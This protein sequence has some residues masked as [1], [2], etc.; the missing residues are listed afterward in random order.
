MVYEGM[1]NIL[2]QI[3]WGG[4]RVGYFDKS[5]MGFKKKLDV[6]EKTKTSKPYQYQ[7]ELQIKTKHPKKLIDIL[8]ITTAKHLLIAILTNECFNF[9]EYPNI[10]KHI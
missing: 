10:S 2:T 6:G 5:G 9:T 4:G 7:T 3:P 8:M 1:E